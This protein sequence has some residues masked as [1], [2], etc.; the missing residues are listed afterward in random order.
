MEN[1]RGL[2][3]YYNDFQFSIFNLKVR[4]FRNFCIAPQIFQ[5]VKLT[6]FLVKNMH[7][8]IKEIHTDPPR[9]LSTFNM[10]CPLAHLFFQ[11]FVD[12]VGNSFYLR[13]GITFADDKEIS[14]GIVQFP[15]I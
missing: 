2:N 9:I 13:V 7:H 14:W 6:R 1:C 12:V 10:G 4:I 15:Q 8:G 5:L 3:Y 11:P